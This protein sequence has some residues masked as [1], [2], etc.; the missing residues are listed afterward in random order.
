M[1]D[2]AGAVSHYFALPSGSRLYEFEIES[3][4]GHGG[5]GITYRAVDTLLGEKVAIKEYLPNEVAIRISDST[6]RAKSQQ[7]LPD[8]DAGLKSFLAEARVMARFR[9]PRIVHVRRFFEL[10]GTGYIVLDYERGK[11]LSERL[12]EGT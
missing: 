5:V 11:T 8:F 12:G 2:G 9:H 3:L 4:L 10:H 7:Q 1:T 6:V